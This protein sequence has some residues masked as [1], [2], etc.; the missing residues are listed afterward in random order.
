MIRSS[1]KIINKIKNIKKLPTLPQ[2]LLKLIEACNNGDS[3]ILKAAS[4]ISKDPSLS[5]KVLQL[6]NSQNLEVKNR[7]FSIEKVVVEL[8]IDTIMTIAISA[9]VEKV[10]NQ[11]SDTFSLK[12]GHFWWHSIMCAIIAKKLAKITSYNSPEEAFLAGQLHDIGKLVLR[13]NFKKE[14]T[15]IDNTYSENQNMLVLEET[16]LGINHCEVGAWLLNQWNLNPFMADA[17]FYHHQQTDDITNAFPIVKIIYTANALSRERNQMNDMDRGIDVAREMFG[18]NRSMVEDIVSDARME[19]A[20]VACTLGILSDMPSEV[21]PDKENNESDNNGTQLVYEIKNYSL[22][23]GI[24]QNLLK[25]DSKDSVIRIVEHGLQILF[26]AV[27][28]IFFFYDA[29]KNILTG[30]KPCNTQHNSMV[31]DLAIPLNDNNSIVSRSFSEIVILDSFGL[32]SK[33]NKSIAEEQL[34]RLLGTEGMLCL[35]MQNHD[36]KVGIII[37]GIDELQANKLREQIKFL[38]IFVNHAAM[39]FHVH[40][41]KQQHVNN[42]QPEKMEAYSLIAR[43]VVHEVNNPLG[44]IKNYLKIL[45]MKLSENHPAQDDLVIVHEEIDRVSQIVDQLSSFSKAETGQKELVDLNTLI[46]NMAKIMNES[47][48]LPSKIDIVLELEDSIPYILTNKNS[49]KQVLINLIKNS[50]EA[51]PNGGNIVVATKI[52][53]GADKIII[54]DN[55]NISRDLEITISDNGPGIP[56]EIKEN[57]FEPYYSSKGNKNSGLG[58]SIVYN[59]LKELDGTIDCIDN[60]GKGTIFKIALPLHA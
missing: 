13:V 55:S 21:I 26:Q 58:M 39:G 25:A 20:N 5:A 16:K 35:P 54:G 12:L 43:K 52:V 7:F 41:M 15:E 4:I 30:H 36:E 50:S 11:E 37:M 57:L 51:M 49:I 48:L 22:L 2:V 28:V 60:K 42:I 53:H 27:N 29:E 10:F 9:S 14:Y 31:H 17:V 23:Y 56:D 38:K 34:I 47:I 46:I 1:C 6:A 44:I 8:G 45:G 19:S 18:L 3:G 24:I 32:K 59:I 40:N 33:K